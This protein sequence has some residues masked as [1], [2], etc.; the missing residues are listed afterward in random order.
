M[1][2]GAHWAGT[3]ILCGLV[4]TYI[5]Q[6]S[7]CLCLASP[8]LLKC[9][10]RPLLPNTVLCFLEGGRRS[11]WVRNWAVWRYFRDYFPIQVKTWCAVLGGC[12]W[13]AGLNCL[14][15]PTMSVGPDSTDSMPDRGKFVGSVYWVK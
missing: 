3:E 4:D 14:G 7:Y 13:C 1:W 15:S 12:R 2:E 10:L 9:P 5:P 11:Q 6:G 8:A